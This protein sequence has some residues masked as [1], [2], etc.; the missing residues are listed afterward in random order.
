MKNVRANGAIIYMLKSIQARFQLIQ[1]HQDWKYY[2]LPAFFG[3]EGAAVF[4]GLAGAG[5]GALIGI[6]GG[7]VG[8]GAGVGG[9]AGAAVGALTG[10][11]GGLV[12]AEH[13]IIKKKL[14][15]WKSEKDKKK[16][17]VQ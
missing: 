13:N 14:E 8:I 4:G 1:F 7:P 16:A 17:S 12:A 3:G 15:Q 5:I 9:A 10:A 2:I 6:A 11:G